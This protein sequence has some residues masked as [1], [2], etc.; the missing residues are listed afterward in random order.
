MWPGE[1]LINYVIQNDPHI[2]RKISRLAGK[3]IRL[4]VK[5]TDVFFS[6]EMNKNFINTNKNAIHTI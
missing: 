1:R 5:D 4:E 3:S 2:E 6:V